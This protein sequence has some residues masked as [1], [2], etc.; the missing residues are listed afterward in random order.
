M[1]ATAFDPSRSVLAYSAVPLDASTLELLQ[2][3]DHLLIHAAPCSPSNEVLQE[4]NADGKLVLYV[5]FNFQLVWKVDADIL[6]V[7]GLANYHPGAALRDSSLAFLNGAAKPFQ[8][9]A[10]NG[11]GTIGRL[12]YE[13]PERNPVAGDLAQ[14]RFDIRQIFNDAAFTYDA[15]TP[16]TATSLP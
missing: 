12:I 6:A 15:G 9:P 14:A 2:P 8:F 16:S 4:T 5:A 13:N 3:E 11:A 7:S 10:S 1:A